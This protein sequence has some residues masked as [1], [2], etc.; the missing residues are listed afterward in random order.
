MHSAPY[1]VAGTGPPPR[2]SQE[3]A[4]QFVPF[5]VQVIHDELILWLFICRRQ[6]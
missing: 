4:S 6:L 3:R 5:P 1:R 2:K